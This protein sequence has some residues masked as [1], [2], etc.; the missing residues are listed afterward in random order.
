MTNLRDSQDPPDPQFETRFA[1]LRQRGLWQ[2]INDW[3]FGYDYF[4]SYRWSDGRAYAVSLAERLK[5]QDHGFECFLDSIEYLKGDN[6]VTVG[7]RALKKTTRL[8]LIGSPE[9]HQST[10]VLHELQMFRA[11]GKMIIPIDFD[12]SLAITA[13]DGSTSLMDYIEP[14]AIVVRESVAQLSM[15]PSDTTIKA[16]TDSFQ[17]ERQRHKRSRVLLLFGIVM[18]VLCIAIFMALSAIALGLP[19]YRIASSVAAL[20]DK[21]LAVK[22][23]GD[24]GGRLFFIARGEDGE[25]RDWKSIGAEL[26]VLDAHG[27]IREIDLYGVV[28]PDFQ[29]LAELKSVNTLKIQ[30][31]RAGVKSWTDLSPLAGLTELSVLVFEYCSSVTDDEMQNLQGLRKLEAL[32]L[33]YCNKLTDDGL[34]HLRELRLSELS[35]E[36]CR[37]VT[38]RGIVALN[39]SQLQRINVRGTGVK[40]TE[41]LITY[42]ETCRALRSLAIDPEAGEK[43][44]LDKLRRLASAR[45]FVIQESPKKGGRLAERKSL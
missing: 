19:T 20:K 7:E 6:W 39:G 21:G 28:V 44:V 22:E 3:L 18:L 25:V 15:G 41:E 5:H 43:D 45:E 37:G 1:A 17:L 31:T 9:A 36:G 26:K 13:D 4:I 38:Q 16:L 35:V 34:F 12:G 23:L 8:I 2:R 29:P 11:L 40:V 24:G 27:T 14:H 30:G 10:A 32:H 33:G 42:L